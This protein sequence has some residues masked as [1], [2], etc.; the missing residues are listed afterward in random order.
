MTMHKQNKNSKTTKNITKQLE[1]HAH[2][3]KQRTQQME[4]TTQKE[5]TQQQDTRKAEVRRNRYNSK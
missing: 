3:K 5:S 4:Y 2:I 1:L